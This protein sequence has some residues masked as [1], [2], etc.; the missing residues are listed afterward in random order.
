M[1]LTDYRVAEIMSLVRRPVDVHPDGV[2]HEIGL[3][4]FG[5]GVFHKPPVH[6]EELGTKKVFHIEPGDLLFSNVFAWE[7]AVALASDREIGKIGSHRFMTYRVDAKKA[8]SRYLMH[9]FYGGPGLRVI[10]EASPGSA[11]RNR[12]LGIKNFERQIVQLPDPDEQRRVANKLD[13]A[14]S[15][16]AQFSTLR[17]H[18][19]QLAQQHQDSLLRPIEELAPLSAAL[20]PSSDF[21]DVAPEED[22]QTAG[23]LNRGR[24]LFRRPVTSGS[25]TKYARYNRLHTGQFVYSK[26]FGWEGSLAVVPAEFEG[27]HVSHEFP[28]FD[29]DP[30]VA[31][32][33]YMSHLARWPGLHDALKDKG[34]GMGSRRQRVNVDRLLATTV[35][36]PSLPEQQRIARQLSIVRQTTEAGA[37]Q[38][39][40]V[41]ALRPVLLNAAFSGQL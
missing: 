2:Y 33:E 16:I 18:S 24:G 14:L 29:I 10:R 21:V 22:Y 6:G 20:R 36:L 37:E 8:D 5:N 35:P 15:R 12:T 25:D 28:T 40:Q 19:S 4:S 38:L 30:S 11:G 1:K 27:V 17:N 41:A 26:L 39:A 9:Y 3:R 7:G 23:I 32:V 13:A 34:T 31:D